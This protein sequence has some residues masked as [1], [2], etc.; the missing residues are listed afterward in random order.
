MKFLTSALLVALLLAAAMALPRPEA[1]P[2]RGFGGYGNYG[3]GG[4]GSGYGSGYGYGGGYGGGFGSYGGYYG[5]GYNPDIW[6]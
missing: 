3:F 1:D 2:Q 6:P 4:Y 5:S